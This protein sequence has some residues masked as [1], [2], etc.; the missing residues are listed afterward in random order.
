MSGIRLYKRII[1]SLL[2]EPGYQKCCSLCGDRFCTRPASAIPGAELM[3]VDGMGHDL[4]HQL[5]KV[6][7]DGIDRT[8]RRN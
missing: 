8:A 2:F 6:I 3:L 1:D 4:P 7:A 5:Y